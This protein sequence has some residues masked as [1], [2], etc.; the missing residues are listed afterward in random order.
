MYLSRLELTDFRSYRRAA[1]E[2]DPGVNVFVGS[3]G[4]G[5][6][7]LVEAVCYLALLRSHRTAT[8]APLVR[9]GSERAVLHGEVLTSGRR[10]DLDVEIVPGRANR[11]RVNGHATRRAR[12]LVG[13]LRVVIFAPEDLALVKGDPAARRDY[14]DDVLVELRPRLFAVRAEYEKALRQRNAF[15]RAVAQDGQQ[16]DRNSL[17]VWNLHFARAAA[18]LLDARRRLVHELAP[19]VE[20]AYAAISGGSGAVRLEYR[21]TVPEEVLQDADEET[22][23]AGI[24]AALRKVQDAELARGLTLVGPHRDDLNLELD[25]RPARGY[26]SHGESWSYALALRLGAYEL[27]R[28]DGETPVMILD[29]V[30]AELDQQRRRRLTGCVSGAEQLL[31]TSA[32]DEPDLPVGRRYVVHESQVHVAD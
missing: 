25:S 30:Y 3:N 26:A 16:V 20:K 13:I 5:K 24:L 31:I 6:T 1:L 22:R 28:S 12:D 14:L 19:F 10:I 27:L 18:A 9:Q 32:V 7:N 23:I 15:L 8:D 11:L 29:D 4:Q 21:S 17:D 2:L